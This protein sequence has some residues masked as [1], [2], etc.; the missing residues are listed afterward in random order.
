MDYTSLIKI[1]LV[2]IPGCPQPEVSEG[3]VVFCVLRF[4]FLLLV[5]HER[6]VAK[7]Q[8]PGSFITQAHT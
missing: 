3:R 8:K 2:G 7:S 4:S 1:D 5:I 6:K